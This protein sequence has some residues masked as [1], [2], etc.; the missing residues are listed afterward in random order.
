MSD[1]HALSAPANYYSLN[2]A[3]TVRLRTQRRVHMITPLHKLILRLVGADG[4]GSVVR[5]D[6]GFEGFN[7][8]YEINATQRPLVAAL[9]CLFYA[10]ARNAVLTSYIAGT[11]R[12]QW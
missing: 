10:D 3:G 4:P 11:A 5:K 1:V 7:F 8:K 6:N 9:C 12:L 2:N